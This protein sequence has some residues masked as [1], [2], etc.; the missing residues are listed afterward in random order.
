MDTVSK[1]TRS[2]IMRSVRQKDTEPELR[3]RKILHRMGF[4]YRLHDKKLP[5]SPDLVFSKYKTVIFVH[6]CFWHRHGCKRTTMPATRKG[7]WQDKFSAN[8]KRDKQ[9]ITD[10][11]SAGWCVMVVWE[12]QIKAACDFKL[13]DRINEFLRGKCS[14]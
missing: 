8:I 10:L 1:T 12:C 13:Y 9:N 3:L 2:R 6:G 5:G 7:F 14:P 11:K 4:R